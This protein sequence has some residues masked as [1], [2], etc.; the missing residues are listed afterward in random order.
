MNPD[1]P[2]IAEPYG[3]PSRTPKPPSRPG[4]IDAWPF[5][6]GAGALLLVASVALGGN[7]Q[8]IVGLG[9]LGIFLIVRGLR[10]RVA[11]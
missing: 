5:C 10:L 6:L 4:W 2:P 11:Q 8:T 9:R 7:I 3:T 1:P